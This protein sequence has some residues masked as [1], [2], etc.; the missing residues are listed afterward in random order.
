MGFQLQEAFVVVST[1][2]N[3]LAQGLSQAKTMIVS[4]IAG[5]ASL[6]ASAATTAFGGLQTALMEGVVPLLEMGSNLE[7]MRSKFTAVFGEEEQAARDFAIAFGQAAGRSQVEL[8]TMLS[9]MQALLVPMGM[10]RESAR[11]MSTDLVQLAVDLGSFNNLADDEALL[12][13][14][15]GIMGE[16]EPLKSLGIVINDVTLSAKLM[17][18]GLAKNAQEASE[19]AKMHARM[20]IIMQ[21]TK[22]AQGDAAKTSDSLA[23]QWKRLQGVLKD[24]GSEIGTALIPAAKG[25]VGVFNQLGAWAKA[26]QERLGQ[27]AAMI[28]EAFDQAFGFL[29]DTFGKLSDMW[30][31]VWDKFGP[32]VMGAVDLATSIF[33]D[34]FTFFTDLFVELSAWIGQLAGAIFDFAGFTNDSI[35]TLAQ[36][37]TQAW[38]FMKDGIVVAVAEIKR[39]IEAIIFAVIN[40]DLTT[41][42]IGIAMAEVFTAIANR[43]RWFAE[44]STIFVKWFLDNFT[45]IAA[46]ALDYVLTGFIN[47]G[48]NIRNVWQAVLDFINT[49]EFKP[50]L[51]GLFD[52]AVSTIKKMPQWKPVETADFSDQWKE[53]DKETNRRMAAW[54]DALKKNAPKVADDT[55]DKMQ[56]ELKLKPPKFNFDPKG[57]EGD[58]KAKKGKDDVGKFSS[59]ENV[60]KD[61]QTNILKGAKPDETPKAQLKVQQEQLTEMKETRKDLRKLDLNKQATFAT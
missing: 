52:G 14:R 44:N 53:L 58:S 60:W 29:V 18:L 30:Q 27:F 25:V 5:A 55:A 17:E 39:W 51:K 46:T 54:Q 16:A 24:L 45:D 20:A 4:G 48:Q 35:G 33:A 15:S 11:G 34:A 21:S 12:K 36:Q 7:E 13:L 1:R 31:S 49:G 47:L 59:L 19:A 32:T 6:A 43:V 10:T 40:W 38:S 41:Q 28:G 3:K 22:D 57:F 37:V 9:D 8:E 2:L 50:D 26:N 56:A 23:N 61:I 42:R